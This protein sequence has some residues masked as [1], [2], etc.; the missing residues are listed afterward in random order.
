MSKNPVVCRRQEDI[1]SISPVKGKKN[2]NINI[3]KQGI[4]ALAI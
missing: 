4:K 2:Y 3:H 1:K